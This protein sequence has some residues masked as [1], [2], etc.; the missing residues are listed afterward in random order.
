MQKSA[1]V[2]D[3]RDKIITDTTVNFIP[4]LYAKK[5]PFRLNSASV[6][7]TRSLCPG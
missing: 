3:E 6:A 2:L 1:V 5:R 4:N 7:R